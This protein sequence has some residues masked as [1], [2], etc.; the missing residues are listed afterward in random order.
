MYESGWDN[1]SHSSIVY[2]VISFAL[3]LQSWGGIHNFFELHLLKVVKW[4]TW[5]KRQLRSYFYKYWPPKGPTLKHK[6]YYHACSIFSSQLHNG[7]PVVLAAGGAYEATTELLDYTQE[8]AKW[9]VS[10][11]YSVS[12]N[13]Q[14]WIN[15]SSIFFT[16]LVVCFNLLK[17]D[18]CFRIKMQLYNCLFYHKMI[19]SWHRNHQNIR[20]YFF[21]RNF[22]FDFFSDFVKHIHFFEARSRFIY[23]F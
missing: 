7:R 3:C 17:I 5:F 12:C 4:V 14:S 13:T 9:I 18:F 20:V 15:E 16:K 23:F 1:A 10:K 11:Y 19:Y 6:R 2:R 22:C 8:N 21:Q